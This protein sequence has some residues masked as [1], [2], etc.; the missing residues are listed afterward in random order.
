MSKKFDKAIEILEKRIRTLEG[1][2][3]KIN[4]NIPASTKS[5]RSFQR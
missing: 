2:L 5:A 4:E 1:R 3:V